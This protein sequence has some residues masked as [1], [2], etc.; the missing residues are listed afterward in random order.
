MVQKGLELDFGVAQHVRV[1]RAAGLVFAQEFGKNAVFV[2]GGEIDMLD[3]DADHVGHG[4]GVQKVLAAGAVLAVIVVFPVFHEDAN[5][6]VPGLLEQP[7]GDGGIH[8]A[9]KA[10]DNTVMGAGHDRNRIAAETAHQ[11]RRSAVASV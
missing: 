11:G 10:D 5:D 4:G 3:V 8:A 1:G 6:F 9:G 2:F 7:G